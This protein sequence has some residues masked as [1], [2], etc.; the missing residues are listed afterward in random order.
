M[1]FVAAA[2]VEDLP[3]IVAIDNH[4]VQTSH[5]SFH[6]QI[7]MPAQ[8]QE[9]FAGFGV[10]GPHR[11]LVA[12]EAGE[13]IG[14]CSSSRYRDL[15]AFD[16]TIEV[17]ININP[18]HHGRGIGTLLYTELFARLADER[19]HVALA[20]IALPNPASIALHRKFGFTEVGVFHEYAKKNG[21]YL[22]SMWLQRQITQT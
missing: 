22:S 14:Y 13:T 18:A 1:I 8:R 11:L 21:T 17:G 7:T 9:W 5:A 2:E 10:Q 20:G 6:T 4:T 12:R 16:E 3:A 15:A 19:V